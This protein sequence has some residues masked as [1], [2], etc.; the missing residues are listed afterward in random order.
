MKD[1]KSQLKS[2]ENADSSKGKPD[3]KNGQLIQVKKVDTKQ[4]TSKARKFCCIELRLDFQRFHLFGSMIN[5]CKE[6]DSTLFFVQLLVTTAFYL[7]LLFVLANLVN[8]QNLVWTETWTVAVSIIVSLMITLILMI[9][10]NH[11]LLSYQRK[12]QAASDKNRGKGDETIIQEQKEKPEDLDLEALNFAQ[13]SHKCG[14]FDFLCILMIIFFFLV[15]IVAA[16]Y[17]WFLTASE[18]GW[19][20]MSFVIT[21]AVDLLVLRPIA[22]IMVA[23]VRSTYNKSVD[24]TG[25]GYQAGLLDGAEKA[26]IGKSIN[27]LRIKTNEDGTKFLEGDVETVAVTNN[28]PKTR[29][30]LAPGS[31]EGRSKTS[32][33]VFCHLDNFILTL[34]DLFENEAEL[35][36]NT[37]IQKDAAS[38]ELTQAGIVLNENGEILTV[39]PDE[40]KISNAHIGSPP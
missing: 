26:G 17:I 29:K 19:I 5:W 6:K 2:T 20:L 35:L 1:E 18:A 4:T 34:D 7:F 40:Q 31:L 13:K 10:V 14:I 39:T 27:R 25:V 15:G 23:I 21:I 30:T 32:S 9:T 38:L 37:R 16:Y 8:Y 28:N 3:N 24:P 22:I 12:K 36:S 11:Y 33:F